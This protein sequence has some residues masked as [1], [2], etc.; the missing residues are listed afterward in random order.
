M[1]EWCGRE[2]V[3]IAPG[4]SP[5][6]TAARWL[7]R[8]A[9]SRLAISEAQVILFL[10]DGHEEFTALDHDI[11]VQLRSGKAIIPVVNKI[12]ALKAGAIYPSSNG[13]RRAAGISAAIPRHQRP[14]DAARL[15]PLVE[16]PIYSEDVVKVAVV[17]RPNGQSAH[18]RHPRRRGSLSAKWPAQ[19]VKPWIPASN[20]RVSLRF[21]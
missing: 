20:T 16:E 9:A 5:S 12:D 7:R 8:C 13:T 18:Q 11:A 2:F 21:H 4:A 3:V 15:L 17:G 10:L 14:S 1:A 19:P 6:G